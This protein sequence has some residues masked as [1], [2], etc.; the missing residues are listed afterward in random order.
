[1]PIDSVR[2]KA[3]L[4]SS[5]ISLTPAVLDNYGLP[6]LEKR[7]AYGNQDPPGLR[8]KKIPQEL[9]LEPHD[10]V[11]AAS[12][13]PDSENVLDYDGVSYF[14]RNAGG[15]KIDVNFSLRPEFYDYVMSTRQKVS[16]VITLYGGHSLGVFVYGDCVHVRDGKACHFCSVSQNRDK[17]TD[18]VKVVREDHIAEAVELAL[19]DKKTD[20]RQVMVNGGNFP[21]L[22]KSFLHYLQVAKAARGAID[23]VG[24]K[25]DMHL[26]ISPPHDLELLRKL[27]GIDVSVAMNTEA[28]DPESF[29]KFCPGKAGMIG[30][31]N[32]FRGLETAVE[33][34]GEGRVYSIFVG[35]LEPLESM[36]KGMRFVSEMGV[37]PVINV[38]HV[39]PETPLALSNYPSPAPEYIMEAG[40]ILQGIYRTYGFKPFYDHCG[41]NSLDTEA[42]NQLF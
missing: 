42:Y 36:E 35:G 15:E 8:H 34:L 29:E 12:V 22:D 39:D 14:I 40:K 10:L 27:S 13:N 25:I 16:Q 4:L 28:F 9:R 38:L 11:V 31:D 3:E 7:R 17:G 6:Y 2:A 41:R 1:M 24:R 18:F 32:I 21:D 26:I 33:V 23:R 5:G 30:R 20:I 37:T 19:G